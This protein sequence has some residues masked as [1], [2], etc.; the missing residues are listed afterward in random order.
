MKTLTVKITDEQAARLAELLDISTFPAAEQIGAMIDLDYEEWQD[1]LEHKALVGST[2][3][4]LASR[5]TRW[6]RFLKTEAN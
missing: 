4:K 2:D 1:N 3:A 5:S 6:L